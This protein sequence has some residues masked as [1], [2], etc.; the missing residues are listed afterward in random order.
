[1]ALTVETGS[2][3]SAADA[4]VSVADVD[5]F[6][7]ARQNSAAWIAATTGAKEIAIRRATLY[8]DLEYGGRWKGRRKY[9]SQALDWPRSW[10]TDRD[11]YS[12]DAESVPVAVKNAACEL[13]ILAIAEELMPAQ[14][15]VGTV[16]GSSVTVGPI[17]ISEQFTGGVTP[18]VF[19]RVDA[20]L[21]G[22]LSDSNELERG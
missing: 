7:L 4:Y 22:L 11:G 12:V 2:G 15:D 19:P 18:R 1:M 14:S 10:V 5:A 3:N 20:L 6:N 9:Q 17:S 13:A 8:M 16:T 21:S